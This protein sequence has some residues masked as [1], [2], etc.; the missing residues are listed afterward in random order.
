MGDLFVINRDKQFEPATIAKILCDAQ[1]EESIIEDR[2]YGFNKE[3]VSLEWII[4][5]KA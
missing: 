3:F 5:M 4:T 2:L 1:I